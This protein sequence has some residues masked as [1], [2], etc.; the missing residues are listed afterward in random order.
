MLQQQCHHEITQCGDLAH[1]GGPA[2]AILEAD[3]P[4]SKR[5]FGANETA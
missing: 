3:T 5:R 1:P 4:A 2:E